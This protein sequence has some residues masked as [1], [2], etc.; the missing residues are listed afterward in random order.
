MTENE[1]MQI[2]QLISSAGSAKSSYMEAISKAKEGNFDAAKELIEEGDKFHLEGHRIHAQMLSESAESV[3]QGVNLI[4]VHAE[5][6][7]MSAETVKILAD[8][9]IEL[10]RLRK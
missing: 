4:L 8:E 1:E 3:E 7:M 10:Y 9:I 2:F 6:Q 5:D